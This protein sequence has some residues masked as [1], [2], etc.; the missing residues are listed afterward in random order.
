MFIGFVLYATAWIANITG[1]VS[2]GEGTFLTFFVGLVAVVGGAALIVGLL[3]S[4]KPSSSISTG[5]EGTI[6]TP[7]ALT[8]VFALTA[9]SSIASVFVGI[10]LVGIG[11]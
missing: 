5:G 1:N 3:K 11:F 10:T 8:G 2:G 7:I 6:T 9:I 4:E